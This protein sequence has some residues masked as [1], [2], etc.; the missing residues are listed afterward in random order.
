VWVGGCNRSQE[1]VTSPAVEDLQK[2]QNN[3][4]SVPILM[5]EVLHIFQLID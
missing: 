1:V 3:N 4:L 5:D 2:K